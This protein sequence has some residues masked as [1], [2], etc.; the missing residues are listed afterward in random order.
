MGTVRALENPII[1]PEN[2]RPSRE[3][4]EVIGV[5]NAGVA[6]YEDEV[7]LL[8]R[9]AE[10]PKSQREDVVLSPIYDVATNEITVKSFARDDPRND[11]SDPRLIV[12]WARAPLVKGRGQNARAGGMGAPPMNR[13]HGQDARATYETYLTS[14]SHLRLARSRDGLRFRIEDRPA[15]GPANEYETF[16][17][18]DPRIACADGVYYVDYVGVAPLGVTTCLA[19]TRDFQSFQRHGVIFHPDNKDVVLFPAR[20]GDKYY[21]LHRP[22]SS[23]FLRNDIWLAESPN[24]IA[25]GRHR[26]LMGTREGWWDE[27]RIGAGAVPFRTDKGWIELYHGADRNSR[28]CLGA[29][30]LDGEQPGKILARSAQPLFEPEAHYERSGFFGQVVFSCGLLFEDNTLKVYYG[31]AD[32]SLCYAEIPLADVYQNLGL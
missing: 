29:V 6:R 4:F 26:Y 15:L 2:V 30:L 17:I 10:R 7:I 27:T 18:E 13:T 1:R 3:D 14:I 32:T 22:H 9:V 8:L 5:F 28:Y 25:W 23:L 11:F 24:L 31:A 19:S 12:A 16:G 20:I 21:A